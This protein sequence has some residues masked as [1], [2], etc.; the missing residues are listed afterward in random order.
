ML[1]LILNVTQ[2]L[3]LILTPCL[4]EFAFLH[5]IFEDIDFV[6]PTLAP[7]T[8]PYPTA[9]SSEVQ[10]VVIGLSSS[11]IM[12][13]PAMVYAL[14]EALAATLNIEVLLPLLPHIYF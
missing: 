2:I 10:F 9:A 8:S 6:A 7:V 3:I 13:Y 14:K 12:D 5:L 1:N 4:P 11:D